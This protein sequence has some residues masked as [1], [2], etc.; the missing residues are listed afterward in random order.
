[1]HFQYTPYIL[2]LIA[3]AAVTLALAVYA[4]RHKDVRGAL[5]FSLTMSL[6]VILAVSYALELSGTDLSTKLTGFNGSQIFFSF[7]PVC[8][9]I[10]VLRF[11]GQDRWITRRNIALLLVPGILLFVLTWTNELHGLIYSQTIMDTSG[12]LPIVSRTI[13]PVFWIFYAYFLSIYIVCEVLLVMSFRRKSALYR[14]QS[15]ALFTGPVLL[16]TTNIMNVLS[17]APLNDYDLTPAV[18]GVFGI[19]LAWSIFRFK[20]FD[21]VP[22]ARENIIENMAVGISRTSGWAAGGDIFSGP[23]G[24]RQDLP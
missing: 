21:I 10:M 9:L 23:A 5:P 15:I 18:A 4:F 14:G 3:T 22:V 24:Y 7:A 8:W 12:D 11:T 13:T 20:L 6:V 2:P 1:M 19:I 17:V 16:F